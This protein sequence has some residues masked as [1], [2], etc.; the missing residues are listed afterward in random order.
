MKI[1]ILGYSGSGKS[2]LAERLG[3]YY[4]A[5]VLHLDKVQ[6]LPGWEER[7][8]EEKKQIVS[9]F[10]DIHESWVIDGNYSTLC[11]SRRIE[12]SDLVIIM[13]FGR[14]SCLLRVFRRYRRYRGSSRPDV[15]EGCGEK[16]DTEFVRWILID[17]RTDR[18]KRF[19]RE[20]A[21]RYA[22]KTVVLRNQRELDQWCA[23]HLKENG[24]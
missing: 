13:L 18:K 1:S 4:G 5:E 15:P 16:L 23:A 2:T 8:A 19:Y 9:E 14:L 21:E 3:D 12:G 7:P 11:F 22:G 10:L 20:T 6:F 17:G 24:I